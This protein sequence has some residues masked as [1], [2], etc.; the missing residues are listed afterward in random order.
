MKVSTKPLVFQSA[1]SDG[2]STQSHSKMCAQ[3]LKELTVFVGPPH[4]VQAGMVM[5]GPSRLVWQEG[6]HPIHVI[7]YK[8]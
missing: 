1:G 4:T 8:M 7:K 2:A 3:R 5:S 6:V